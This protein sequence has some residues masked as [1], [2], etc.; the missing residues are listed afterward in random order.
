M[1]S[2]GPSQGS[3]HSLLLDECSHYVRVPDAGGY[4]Q[5]KQVWHE[6]GWRP[7]R[8]VDQVGVSAPLV[9]RNLGKN[10]IPPESN[11]L[12]DADLP[13]IAFH[14]SDGRKEFLDA[15]QA[16][17]SARI[18]NEP[19]TYVWFAEPDQFEKAGLLGILRSWQSTCWK[20]AATGT[21]ISASL[22]K[23]EYE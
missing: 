22:K 5:H 2:E 8:S 23:P 14:S 6:F 11:V 12:A 10:P 20:V 17:L 21:V 18:N 7:F 19:D 4:A 1:K 13:N 15:G 3:K 9:P 16:E